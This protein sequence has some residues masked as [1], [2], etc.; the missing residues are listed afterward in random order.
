MTEPREPVEYEK[1]GSIVAGAS[2][3]V[4]LAVATRFVFHWAEIAIEQERPASEG[5]AKYSREYGATGSYH[6]AAELY[7]A[8]IGIAACAH[9][10]DALYAEL[11][12]LVDRDALAERAKE[13]GGRRWAYVAAALE[14]AVD[15]DV[16]PWQPRIK[17]LFKQLRDPAVHPS[18]KAEQAVPHP[19]LEASTQPV[20]AK[21]T[22][23]ALRDSVDLLLEILSACV[24]A[25]TPEVETWAS[26]S[27]RLVEGLKRRAAEQRAA[28]DSVARFDP[29]AV[30]YRSYDR[31]RDEWV[32]DEKHEAQWAA[33]LARVYEHLKTCS[34]DNERW[35]FRMLWQAGLDELEAARLISAAN[36]KRD[37]A[38]HR[39]ARRLSFPWYSLRRYQRPR[40]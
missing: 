14:L 11:R 19:V 40:R 30:G 15:R 21:Y 5:R 3:S 38:L 23:E 17:K 22:V 27:R 12:E 24:E 39:H 35:A 2:V 10:L 36:R 7:P 26:D 31:E 8:M 16:G 33:W 25:P 28:S 1:K 20:Y 4:E 9:A 29:E 13:T 32:F 18:A 6:L 37:Q 34:L